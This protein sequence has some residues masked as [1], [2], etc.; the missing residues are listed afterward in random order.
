MTLIPDHFKARIS[1][2]GIEATD[3]YNLGGL[4]AAA[5]EDNVVSTLNRLRDRWD[6]EDEWT[7]YRFVRRAE[8]FPDVRL[9]RSSSER[10]VLGI[11]LK[12]WYLLSKE[13]VPSFR[14]RI[15]PEACAEADLLVVFP[16]ALEN[17]LAGEPLLFRPFIRSCKYVAEYRNYW[18]Q[19]VRKTQDPR[20][21]ALAEHRSPYPEGREKVEDKP[22][23]NS[24][25][26]FGRIARTGIM[27]EFI[28]ECMDIRL[29]GVEVKK[30][31]DFLASV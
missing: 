26:N 2:S 24:G 25:K 3:I 12:S 9:V 23:Y 11:E 5:I 14:F 29:A 10:P 7:D 17:V 18:W 27:D 16:W 31:I 13:R 22:E 15:T 1:I 28:D 4:I 20:G 6:P 8:T 30:W 19:H 21:I